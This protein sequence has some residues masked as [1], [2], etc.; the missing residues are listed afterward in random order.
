MFRPR[1]EAQASDLGAQV[2]DEAHAFVSRFAVLP[3]AAALDAVV[4]WAAHTWV[5]DAFNASPRLAVLSDHPAS[6]KTRV[7]EL[8]G[9]LSKDATVE[10]DPTGPAL[11]A[12]ISQRHPTILMDEVD[13]IYG[14]N[15]GNSH[16]ALRA[17]LNSGYKQGATVSR[18]SGGAFVQESIFGAVAFGGLGVL[19][20]T[21]MSR[22]IV[23]RMERR[24]PEQRV[25]SYFPRLH[26]GIGAG[27][28]QALGSWCSTVALDLA[29][30]WPTLP[31]GIEDRKAEIWEA[32]LAIA[33]AA[34]GDWPERAR[35]ACVELALDVAAE[36]VQSPGQRVLRD[37]RVAWSS[38]GNLPTSVLITRL[39]GLPDAPWR[40]LW[41]LA[42]APRELAAL[43]APYNVR[44]VKIRTGDKTVQGYRR[45]D[46][47]AAW[48]AVKENEDNG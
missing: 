33:E 46:A 35:A 22:S 44:P 19:P 11:V 32:L 36:P 10:V 13:C 29:T 5:T 38:D 17:I 25:E 12:M 15:G 37:L 31:D 6:G 3:G 4:L 18:R 28:G 23:I 20:G 8:V 16:R 14:T 1:E 41:P 30:A 34:G 7:L 42:S 9:L 24:R 26:E 47:E 45:M 21:L 27:I 43:L 39:F 48:N 2:L 40:H